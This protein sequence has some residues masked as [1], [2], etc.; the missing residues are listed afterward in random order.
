MNSCSPKN[1]SVKEVKNASVEDLKD[2]VTD[3]DVSF[4]PTDNN[5][6]KEAIVVKDGY[7]IAGQNFLRTD[8][9]YHRS[10]LV[11]VSLNGELMKKEYLGE[12]ES[13]NNKYMETVFKVKDDRI[14]Q[15]GTKNNKLWIREIDHDLSLIKDVSFSAD[16]STMPQPQVGAKIDNFMVL[17]NSFYN[18][19]NLFNVSYINYDDFNDALHTSITREDENVQH[20]LDYMMYDA[21][22]DSKTQNFFIIGT[23]CLKKDE[24]GL[25]D[26]QEKSIIIYNTNSKSVEKVIPFQTFISHRKNKSSINKILMTIDVYKGRI[27]TA[28]LLI[29]LKNNATFET[30]S[31]RKSFDLLVQSYTIAGEKVGEFRHTI[32]KKSGRVMDLLVNDD[33]IHIGGEVSHT[34]AYSSAYFRFDLQGTLLEQRTFRDPKSMESRI[35]KLL[36]TPDEKL[37]LLGKG[38]GWRILKK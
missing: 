28:G 6:V 26:V 1:T 20:Y 2:S 36:I 30:Y 37:L 5:F 33:N 7:I 16:M 3:F 38:K 14:I 22:Y 17:Y 8:S 34:L 9:I 19:H 12:T 21:V 23:G 11:K 15:I 27:Y 4:F 32:A 25:C 13:M 35:T 10:A 29:D 31:Q 18:R 24:K